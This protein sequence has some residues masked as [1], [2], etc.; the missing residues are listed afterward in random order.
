ML[1]KKLFHYSHNLAVSIRND[2][3]YGLKPFA[4]GGTKPYGLWVS[5][6][7]YDDSQNWFSWCIAEEYEI[8]SLKYRHIVKLNKNAKILWLSTNQEIIDFSLKYTAHDPKEYAKLIAPRIRPNYI[9]S[10][11]WNAIIEKYDGIIIAPYSW[12]CRLNPITSWYYGWDC[13]SG[14]IWNT[15][16]IE[17]ERDTTFEF[18]EQDMEKSES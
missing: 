7:D 16:C 5:V 12:E 9:Y 1:P 18:Q 2:Y 6:E 3:E 10:I 17:I 4:D 14:C 8:P 11:N 13:A 15:E